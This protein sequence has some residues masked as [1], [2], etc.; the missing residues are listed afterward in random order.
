MDRVDRGG[1]GNE[2]H[3]ANRYRDFCAGQTEAVRSCSRPNGSIAFIVLAELE[4]R[5]RGE[6]RP[7][8]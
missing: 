2:A 1:C 3:P 5:I 6:A 7:G 4:G 8:K